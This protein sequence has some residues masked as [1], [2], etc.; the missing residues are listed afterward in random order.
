[1]G[2]GHG[3]YDLDLMRLHVETL[4]THDAKGRMSAVNEPGGA[5]APR[6]FLGRTAAGSLWRFRHDLVADTVQALEALCAE[7]SPDRDWERPENPTPFAKILA[8]RE[9]VEKIWSGPVFRF[10]DSVTGRE[11]T[12]R[13]DES[14]A[15]VLRP[16]FED[17][18]GAVRDCQPFVVRLHDGRAVSLCS[19]VRETAEAYEAGVETAPA[20]RGRAYATHVVAAWADAVR[21]TDRIP[22]YS[23]SWENAASQRVAN[24]L[25]LFRFGNDVHIT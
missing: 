4:F 21:A 9:P 10:P 3:G 11:E 22:L 6:F 5:P 7:L 8:E 25:G 19:T 12:V 20:F 24:K 15:D 14:N 2:K 23:T 18:L 13:V 16:H 17:W 1:M